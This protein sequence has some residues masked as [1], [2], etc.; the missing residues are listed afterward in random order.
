M[1]AKILTEGGTTHSNKNFSWDLGPHYYYSLDKDVLDLYKELFP[2]NDSMLL[3][4][5]NAKI[6]TWGKYFDYPIKIDLKTLKKLG[7]FNLFFCGFTWLLRCFHKKKY[8]LEDFF[9]GQYGRGLYKNFFKDY[10]HKVWG[11]YPEYLPYDFLSQRVER[12]GIIDILKNTFQFAKKFLKSKDSI[13]DFFQNHFLYPRCGSGEFWQRMTAKIPDVKIEHDVQIENIKDGFINC[14]ISGIEHKINYDYL[15]CSNTLQETLAYL[16]NKNLPLTE[17]RSLILIC[18]EVKDLSIGGGLEKNLHYIYLHDKCIDAG[19]ITIF[20]NWSKNMVVNKQNASCGLEYYCDF[21]SNLW[22]LSST[23]LQSLAV[24]DMLKLGYIKSEN[25]VIDIVIEKIKYAYPI[26]SDR[27]KISDCVKNLEKQ[28]IFSIGRLGRH[29]YKSMGK[30]ME[31]AINTA[32]RIYESEKI[33][34]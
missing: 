5:K 15:V 4:R 24:N 11:R 2:D 1:N 28:K 6:Y 10:T 16:K 25:Q 22:N 32:R 29:E 8:S 31:D 21:K 13:N 20:S 12:D 33:F 26:I 17:F 34:N 18:L 14:K 27:E 7:F 23:Q 3:I 9:V 30:A 19:R